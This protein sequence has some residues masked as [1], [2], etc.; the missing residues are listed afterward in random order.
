[1]LKTVLKIG[2]VIAAAAIMACGAGQ[3]AR[4]LNRCEAATSDWKKCETEVTMLNTTEQSVI[5]N[6]EWIDHDIKSFQGRPIT[7][8]GGELAAHK[9]DTP[10]R[11]FRLCLGQHR[12]TWYKQG[13]G[14]IINRYMFT[15]VPGTAKLI[16]TPKGAIPIRFTPADPKEVST[17]SLIQAAVNI[18]A[19]ASLPT[20]SHAS[21]KNIDSPSIA[22]IQQELLAEEGIKQAFKDNYDAFVRIAKVTEY[23]NKVLLHTSYKDKNILYTMSVRGR[24]VGIVSIDFTKQVT[25]VKDVIN[26][27]YEGLKSDGYYCYAKQLLKAEN[28]KQ[29][30]L[31]ASSIFEQVIVMLFKKG[32]NC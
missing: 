26:I 31:P 32:E 28:C 12:V 19:S 8:C 21:V 10:S 27:Y 17:I 24:A 16:I 6:V 22:A 30:D 20:S 29:V 25:V 2:L 23:R 4:D 9:S 3:C 18:E 11:L 1:M 7:R 13:S 14:K 5:Y 15:I